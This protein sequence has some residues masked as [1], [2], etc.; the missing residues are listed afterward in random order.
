MLFNCYELIAYLSQAM[1]LE[2]GDVITTGTPAGVGVSMN[3]R[4]YLTAGQTVRVAIEQLGELINPII[5]EP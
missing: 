4:G 3:P 1:T 5:P 2:P